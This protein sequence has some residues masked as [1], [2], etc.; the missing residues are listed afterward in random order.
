MYER[1]DTSSKKKLQDKKCEWMRKESD[2]DM[3]KYGNK[4]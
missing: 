1:G 2:V 4:H 3:I